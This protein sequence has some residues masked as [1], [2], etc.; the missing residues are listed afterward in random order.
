MKLFL[1]RKLVDPLLDLLKQ[2]ITP[3][4]L[5]VSAVLGCI[6]GVFPVLGSTVILCTAAAYL[7]RL[8]FA[9]I[10]TVNY[11]VYPLQ[12]ALFIPFIRVGE[13]ILNS[14]P[15]PISMQEIFK[16]LQQDII[17]AIQTFWTANLHGIFAWTVICPVS[18][19]AA[20]FPV[21]YIFVKAGKKL[22]EKSND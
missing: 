9:A 8:N 17:L 6:L 11:L 22:K 4:K 5:A 10:Q 19:F 1:K 18:A 14:E 12:L 20:Y 2:G 16:L 21:K 15:F 3:E 7:F 13:F